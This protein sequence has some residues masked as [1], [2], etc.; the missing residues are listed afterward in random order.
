[1]TKIIK[2][3]KIRIQNFRLIDDITL[4]PSRGL[5]AISGKNGTAKSTLLGMIAQGFSFNNKILNI[6][7]FED[8]REIKKEDFIKNFNPDITD[9]YYTYNS[10]L[11]YLGNNFE[12][13][14]AEH[15][16]LSASDARGKNHCT[17]HLN[18]G[19]YFNIESTFHNK[20]IPRLVTRRSTKESSNYVHPVIYLGLGRISPIVQS[21]NTDITLIIPDNIKKLIHTQY[22]SILLKPY[23]NNLK[24]FNTS[25]KNKKTAAFLPNNRT[26]EM[27]SSGEDNLGQ[28][29]LSVFSFKK[30]KETLKEDY[31]GGILLID[32]IDAT[33][34][35]AAQIKLIDFLLEYSKILNLQIFFTTHSMVILEHLEALNKNKNNKSSIKIFSTTLDNKDNLEISEIEH[36][37]ILKNEF[38]VT[39]GEEI[40]TNKINIYFEDSEAMYIFNG[41]MSNYKTSDNKNI[42]NRI[43][44]IKSTLSCMTYKSL[45]DHKI[46]EFK[47]HSIICVDGDQK[48]NIDKMKT[49]IELPL[50]NLSPEEFIFDL[51]DDSTSKYWQTTTNYRHTHFMNNPHYQAVKLI[52]NGLFETECKNVASG[53]YQGKKEREVWKLWFNEEK[54]NWK[55]KNNP[56]KYFAKENTQ[57]INKFTN[58][59]EKAFN[60][61]AKNLGIE[62]L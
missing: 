19:D 27:I 60:F 21:N 37:Y 20:S 42:T 44:K 48:Y 58:S 8:I 53:R 34:Y 16:K 57:T 13:N 54:S 18:T 17:V 47:K 50:C 28:I 49:F 24:G 7:G 5:N 46:P 11:T 55:K 3:D 45:Y 15:F 1:M 32:E 14:S 10:I 22:E 52:K 26:I 33:L 35:A 61:V 30:L 25:I 38:L 40:I 41:L 62:E 43:N 2:I 4:N 36:S 51:L 59:F 56:V 6:P 23:E 39:T 9:K 31:R 29:L 12:S